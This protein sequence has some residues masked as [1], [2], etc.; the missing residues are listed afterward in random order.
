MR[1]VRQLVILGAL[2]LASMSCGDVVRDSRSPVM[3]V[4]D[5]MAVARG[6]SSTSVLFQSGPLLSDVLTLVTTPAPCTTTS[7]C[8]TVFNDFGQ[9]TFRLALRNIGTPTSPT[10]FSPNN[11]VTLTRYHVEYVRTDGRRTPGVD[12]PYAFDGGMTVTA[13]DDTSVPV[14]FELVRHAAKEE[15]PLVQ[16]VFSPVV[17]STIANITFYGTDRVGNVISATGSIQVDFG[18]F[19][20]VQ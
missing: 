4:I 12:V 20:D 1:S 6:S 19:G 18:N 10:S 9:A 5:S 11:A 13:F 15:A 16:L 3:I 7:P 8:P 2:G 14:T 17:I